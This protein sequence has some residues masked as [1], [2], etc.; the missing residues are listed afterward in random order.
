MFAL[1]LVAVLLNAAGC[2]LMPSQEKPAPSQPRPGS[3]RPEYSRFA[4][5]AEWLI[6]YAVYLRRLNNTDLNREHE[7]VRQQVAK[8]RTDLNRAQLGLIYALPGLPLRDEGRALAIFESL[9]KEAA[10]PVAR[11]FALLML[12]LVADNKRLD[13]SVQALSNRLK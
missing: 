11:N 2:H 12:G 9:G 6:Q 7:A 8:S 1:L 10:S 13:D 4:N 5:E 3:P